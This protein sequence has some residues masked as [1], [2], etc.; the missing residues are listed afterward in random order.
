[1]EEETLLLKGK[2]EV[3]IPH[4][5]RR[6]GSETRKLGLVLMSKDSGPYQQTHKEKGQEH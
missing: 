2:T 1:M 6:Q 3:K 4:Q 5:N